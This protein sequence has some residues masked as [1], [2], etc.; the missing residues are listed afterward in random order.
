MKECDTRNSHIS[1]KLHMFCISSNNDRHPIT[2]T[3][4]TLHSSSLHL[5]TLHFLSFKL[6]PATLHYPLI[7]L[8]P[9]Q[10]P[11]APFHLT[12]TTLHLTHF[13]TPHFTSQPRF[14]P[15]YYILIFSLPNKT[16]SILIPRF[17]ISG[18]VPSLLYMPS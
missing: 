9:P 11:P 8:N 17:R 18:V 1:S 13:T 14:L 7:W 12:I 16:S 2:K 10:F 6:Q 15:S 4:T 5:S 3:F